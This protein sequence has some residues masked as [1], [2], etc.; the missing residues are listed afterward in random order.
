MSAGRLRFPPPAALALV[1]GASFVAITLLHRGGTTLEMDREALLW[2]RELSAEWLDALGAFEDI[3]FQ[4]IVTLAAAL[5]LSVVLW[6]S[7]P[8]WSWCAPMSIVLVALAEVLVRN[9]W[10]GVMHPRGLIDA[11]QVLWGGHYDTASSFPS[12][13]VARAMFLAVIVAYTLPR[14]VSVPLGVFA[15]ASV[16]ARLYTEA[17]FFSD[18]LG[19]TALG[20]AVAATT[21]WAI[22]NLVGHLA[23]MRN[24]VRPGAGDS[25]GAGL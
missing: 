21:L 10:A 3:A 5:V 9:G 16:P 6:R 1:A 19:G 24:G 7:G 12:G 20:I 22:P 17:H 13:H 25:A 8:A 2:S 11:L 15:L 14:R 23:Y 4:P 18:V